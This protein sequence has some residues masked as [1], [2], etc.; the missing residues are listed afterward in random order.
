MLVQ[1]YAFAGVVRSRGRKSCSNRPGT[2]L[3]PNLGV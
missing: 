2:H 1:V 3:Q